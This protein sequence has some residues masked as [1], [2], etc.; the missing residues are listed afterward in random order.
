M[1]KVGNLNDRQSGIAKQ[2]K[3]IELS[4][5]PKY[6]AGFAVAYFADKCICTA[7]VVDAQ[8]MEIKEKTYTVTKPP[9]NYIP[10]LIA[11]RE[12]PVICQTYYDLEYEPDVLI[13]SGDGILHPEKAGLANFVGTELS[14]P[15]IGVGTKLLSGEEQE[16]RIFFNGEL[17]GKRV[18]TK[19]HAKPLYV[20][21]GNLITVEEA[22]Q[23]VKQCVCL[24]HKLPEPLHLAHRMAS[25]LVEKYKLEKREKQEE[26]I[27]T[28][29]QIDVSC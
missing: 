18:L 25:K 12:G 22:A 7:V 3:V 8:T 28:E 29:R 24:P 13:V 9:I 11:F 6:F 21:P 16:D 10:G 2:I 14:K 19:E 26:Q 20:S 4:E 27:R 1:E 17:T 5:V 23:I 15:V